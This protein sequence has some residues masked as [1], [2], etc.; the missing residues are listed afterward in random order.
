MDNILTREERF[1]HSFRSLCSEYGYR[2]YRMSKFEEYDLYAGNRS[3]LPA[4]GVITFTD[5]NG[6]LMALKP[7]VTLSIA[8][9][10]TPRPGEPVRVYYDESVYRAPDRQLGFQEI[11]QAGLEYLGDV[12][13]Y[14]MGEVVTLAARS[15][16]AIDHGYV[17]DITHMG[18]VTGLIDAL[19]LGDQPRAE[20]LRAIGMRNAH[21]IRDICSQA[22]AAG[23]PAQR[24]CRVASLYGPVRETIAELRSMSVNSATERAL[25]EL[26]KLAGV[27]ESFGVLDRINLDLSITSDMEYY[28]G[29]LFKGYVPG[30]PSAVLSGGRYDSLLAKL[31]KS[32]G[33]IGFALYLN[34]LERLLEPSGPEYDADVLLLT[35]QHT[36]PAA[37]AAAVRKMTSGGESVLVQR[38]PGA[39]RCRRTVHIDSEG[40]LD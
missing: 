1:V 27:L 13:Y 16:D 5:T 23:A 31:G 2:P 17:L 4:G 28:N 26:D 15:L 29:L 25:A 12:D 3:F 35:G 11:T 32:G 40:R 8:K 7:D 33:A 20:L 36:P 39:A 37:V 24:L 9:N 21:G 38:W 14:A 34:L 22:G 18:F 6:R 30:V 19:G 10:L